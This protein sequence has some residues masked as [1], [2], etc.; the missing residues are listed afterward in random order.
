MAG[1]YVDWDEHSFQSLR[2]HLDRLD[3]V[4]A[5]WA[6]I[7]NSGDTLRMARDTN[8]VMDL[9]KQVPV[10]RRPKILLMVSNV[11]ENTAGRFGGVNTLRLLSDTAARHRAAQRLAR[12]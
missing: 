11:L 2:A 12:R 4:I 5:E 6:F 10:A 9:I 7:A 1:F 3:W 8:R